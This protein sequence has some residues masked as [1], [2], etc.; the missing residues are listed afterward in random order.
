MYRVMFDMPMRAPK[1]RQCVVLGNI[2]SAFDS[3]VLDM[4]CCS[5][6]RCMLTHGF[7]GTAR[8]DLMYG[9]IVR[10]M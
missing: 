9:S 8:C 4:N 5:T 7:G 3:V 6:E 1:F 2:T 10:E